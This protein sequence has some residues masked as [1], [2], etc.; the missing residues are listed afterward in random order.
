MDGAHDFA[1]IF[2][3]SSADLSY[4]LL[5]RAHHTLYKAYRD[6]A[7]QLFKAFF[8]GPLWVHIIAIFTNAY[9]IY[10]T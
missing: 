10:Y 2:G 9:I 8:N 3:V 1:S 6:L 4:L 5:C 7:A